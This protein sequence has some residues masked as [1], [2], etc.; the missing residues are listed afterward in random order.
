LE[1][2]EIVETLKRCDLFCQ[3]DDK[4]IASIAEFCLID[5]YDPG[6]TIFQQG[7]QG[8]KIYIVSEGQVFLERTIDMG[9][10]KAKATISVL[11]R[12]KALGCWSTIVGEP[13]TLMCSAKCYKPTKVISIE[14]PILRKALLTDFK[15]GFKVMERLVRI[16]WDRVQGAY[17][18]MENL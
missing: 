4:E 3:L 14:G 2:F 5:K 13:H 1:F 17:G 8:S 6:E 9:H 10:R 18:A 12:G 15:A 11:G 7:D 16:L